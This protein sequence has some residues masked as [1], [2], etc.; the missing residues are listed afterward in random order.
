MLNLPPEVF[1]ALL[2][3][4]RGEGLSTNTHVDAV[5]FF[6]P[7]QIRHPMQHDLQLAQCLQGFVNARCCFICF[8]YL[9]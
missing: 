2:K 8:L 6:G 1:T 5:D 7:P 9:H 4:H 3:G